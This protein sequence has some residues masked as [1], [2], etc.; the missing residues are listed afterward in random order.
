MID[1][2]VEEEKE[3]NSGR[4]HSASPLFALHRLLTLAATQY[5]LDK[6]ELWDKDQPY[7]SIRNDGKYFDKHHCR[8]VMISTGR[9]YP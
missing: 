9:Q 7:G 1:E 2:E 8:P 3:N 4:D 6:L 5:I